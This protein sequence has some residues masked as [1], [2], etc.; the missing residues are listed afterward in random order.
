MMHDEMRVH[1]GDERELT[2]A[3]LGGIRRDEVYPCGSDHV[4][5]PACF[6]SA[7]DEAHLPGQALRASLTT[8]RMC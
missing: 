8:S 4:S 2:L 1:L 6:H 7:G 5:E 3:N